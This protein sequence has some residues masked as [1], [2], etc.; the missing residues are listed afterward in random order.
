MKYDPGSMPLPGA[1]PAHAVAHVDPIGATGA[2]YRT[3][4]DRKDHSLALRERHDLRTRLH[5]RPLLGQHEVSAGEVGIR[6]RE[7]K[8][9]LQRKD[10]LSVE[11]LMQAVVV[12][13]TV[14]QEERRRLGLSGVVAA[15][16]KRLVAIRIAHRHAHRL[17]PTVR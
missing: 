5:A 14:L 17:I 8:R 12:A 11:I 16:Q 6:A 4:V 9:D 15:V 2:A 7:Q 1:D 13:L 3:M 10:M